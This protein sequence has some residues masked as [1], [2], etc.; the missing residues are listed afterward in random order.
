M[1]LRMLFDDHIRFRMQ[2]R[3]GNISL[4]HRTYQVAETLTLYTVDLDVTA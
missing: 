4:A 2:N 3:V 1:H